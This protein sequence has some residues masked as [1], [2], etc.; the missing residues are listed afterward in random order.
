M[1]PPRL[2]LMAS[3]ESLY[4]AAAVQDPPK[5]ALQYAGP[6]PATP[7]G[8]AMFSKNGCGA[9]PGQVATF[10]GPKPAL[11]FGTEQLP[12]PR[13]NVDTASKACANVWPE[14]GSFAN[15][16]EAL[17]SPPDSRLWVKRPM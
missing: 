10:P 12:P 15:M 7:P 3:P 1:K 16:S 8:T 11:G 13:R 4:A 2:P 17:M 9:K 6:A 5:V 14:T